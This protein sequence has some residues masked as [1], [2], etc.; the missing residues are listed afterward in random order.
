MRTIHVN[1]VEQHHT[2]SSNSP[3]HTPFKAQTKDLK[4]KQKSYKHSH[5]INHSQ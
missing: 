4:Q 2:F 5:S 3:L 1:V